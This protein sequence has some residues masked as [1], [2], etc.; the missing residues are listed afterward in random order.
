[1]KKFLSK[2][3]MLVFAVFL[4][5][6]VADAAYTYIFTNTAPRTKSKYII[7]LKDIKI[8]YIF[9]GS[10]R[11]HYHVN[12][13]MIE[14][15]TSK[16]ALNLGIDAA[17]LDDLFLQLKL[18]VHNN[19]RFEKIFIQIDYNFNQTKPSAIVSAEVLPYLRDNEVVTEQMRRFHP[20]FSSYYYVPFYRYQDNEYSIGFRAA[21]LNAIGVKKNV[22][23]SD[24][25]ATL[26]KPFENSEP[27]L[28]TTIVPHNSTFDQM[29]SFCKAHHLNVV[30][31]TAPYCDDYLG[32]TY[33]DKLK[34]KIPQL[35]DFSKSMPDKKYFID[36]RH[37]NADG[38]IVFTRL[39][40]AECFQPSTK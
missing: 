32:S 19:V 23:F 39:L 36:C 30:F 2:V 26:D 1:M 14:E 6:V 33:Q 17:S 24:G 4:I 15:S 21:L 12:T 8:D 13:K 38:A 34:A 18:L 10:S 28:P 3:A 20:K 35:K 22:D 37:L 5:M 7:Q 27:P 9:L 11:T 29:V 40:L 16:K 31:F 25:F